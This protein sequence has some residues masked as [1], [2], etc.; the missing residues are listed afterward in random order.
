MPVVVTITP[1]SRLAV[2]ASVL[3]AAA[4]A[5]TPTLA[6]ANTASATRVSAVATSGA[7]V[8]SGVSTSTV[9]L[10]PLEEKVLRR[11]NGYRKKYGRSPLRMQKQLRRAALAHAR[12]MGKQGFFEHESASGETFDARIKRY[13]RVKGL[14]SWSVGEN[15]VWASGKLSAKRAIALWDGSPGHR[16]N[17]RDGGWRQIGVA[18]LRVRSAPGVFRGFDVTIRRYRLRHALL[19]GNPNPES[20]RQ[21]SL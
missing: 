9:R 2:L 20:A 16:R 18:A 5:A 8:R 3:V 11:L 7:T 17:M 1:R 10:K 12:A 19:L 13:Y 14:R 4:F 6:E 21:H 15:L